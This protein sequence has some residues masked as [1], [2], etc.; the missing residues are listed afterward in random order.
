V[1]AFA[2]VRMTLTLLSLPTAE[3]T[4]KLLDDEQ[5]ACIMR[6]AKNGKREFSPGLGGACE[7]VADG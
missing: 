1:L 2:S 4:R 6:H 3:R 7:I 5:P